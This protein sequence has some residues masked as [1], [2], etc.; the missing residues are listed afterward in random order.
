MTALMM[1][2]RGLRAAMAGFFVL[3]ACG[4]QTRAGDGPGPATVSLAIKE[5]PADVAC[6]RVSAAGARTTTNSFDVKQGQS[7]VF[8][9]GG[10]PVGAVSFRAEAFDGACATATADAS[11]V[12]DVVTATLKPGKNDNLTLTMRAR[13]AVTVGV[14]FPG[15]GPD[16]KWVSFDSS[17]VGTLAEALV[18]ASASSADKT[19]FRLTLHGLFTEDR[20]GPDGRTYQRLFVPGLSSLDHPG[21]PALPVLRAVIGMITGGDAVVD[22]QPLE[23]RVLTGLTPWPATRPELDQ[24]APSRDAPGSRPEEFVRDAAIYDGRSP[25]PAAASA[26]IEPRQ[27]LVG[28]LEGA[29]VELRPVGFNPAEGSV[30]LWTR[31]SFTVTHKGTAR[32]VG[33]LQQGDAVEAAALF[34]N[35]AVIQQYLP[36]ATKFAGQ[37]LF[38]SPASMQ[39]ELQPLA[40]QKKARGFTVTMKTLEETGT[41][42]ASIRAAIQSWHASAGLASEF[43]ALLVG[44]TNKIPLCTAPVNGIP[45]DDLYGSTNGDDLNPE[46]LVGRLSPVTEA[47]LANQVTKILRYEDTPSFSFNYGRALLV[48]HAQGAP[49]KYVGAQEAVR[50]AV[51]G[52]PPTFSTVYGSV[53]GVGNDD[54]VAVMDDGQG[55][56]AYRGHGSE[57][58]WWN[59]NLD[60]LP[61]NVGDAITVTNAATETPVLWSF[62]CL[63]AALDSSPSLTEIWMRSPDHLAVASYGAT[64]PSGTDANHVLDKKM[65]E[66]VYTKNLT[67]HARAIRWAEKQMTLAFPGS[68]TENAWMY[69]MLGDPEMRI[70]RRPILEVGNIQPVKS[71]IPPCASGCTVDIGVVDHQGKPLTGALVLIY[72]ASADGKTEV[73]DNGYTDSQGMVKLSASAGTPGYIWVRARSN[74]DE[75]MRERIQ[76]AA[77][78]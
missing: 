12:S 13:A 18:D 33:A 70:R 14:D 68:G 17:P 31:A 43:Y 21:A 71:I 22:A 32:F 48:A 35:W 54:V 74:G 73:A 49:G 42:C 59:W 60:G 47:D 53:P 19:V 40:D 61:F 10:L 58:E 3:A 62:A 28:P 57:T 5:A 66:A 63:N 36:L 23:Q 16:A 67:T 55:V 25:Y 9:L 69:L 64:V 34:A 65:F 76:V 26:V 20:Q 29:Q 78:Q 2:W 24:T 8:T 7:T 6:I 1:R 56:V 77:P 41:T 45:T 38:L 50:T 46:V 39:D 52:T 27:T 11:W 15:L 75:L 30:T 72:K 37:F 4:Q 51:Y 44:D